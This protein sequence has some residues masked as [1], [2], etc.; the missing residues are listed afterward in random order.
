[1]GAGTIP[2]QITGWP[3]VEQLHRKT[4]GEAL[5]CGVGV[6]IGVK[7]GMMVASWASPQ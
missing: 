2:R 3:G 7:V 1:L 5:G 6:G 4:R